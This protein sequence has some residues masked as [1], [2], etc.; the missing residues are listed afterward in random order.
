MSAVP[1]RPRLGHERVVVL[2]TLAGGAPAL[3]LL[4][5]LNWRGQGAASRDWLL[6][7]FAAVWWFVL[8]AAVRRRVV[9]PL[10]TLGNLLACLRDGDTSLRARGAGTG[11]ALAEVMLEA[12]LL[13]GSLQE[14]RLDAREAS[15][16]L[17]RVMAEIDV[18]VC[19]FDADRRTR[20]VNHAGERLLGEPVDRLLNRTADALGLGPCLDAPPG[21]LTPLSLDGRPGRWEV[22]RSVFRLG[23]VPHTLLVLTDV[24]RSLRDEERQAWQRLIRVLGHE[25]NNSLAPIRSIAASLARLVERQWGQADAREDM[26]RGLGVVA[27]RA[28]ALG[29]FTAASS[30][31]A[32]LPEP[33]RRT[34]DL[35]TLIQ[36]VAALDHRV[37]VCVDAGL[38]AMVFVDP[39]QFEQVLINLVKNGAE[40]MAG[41]PGAV[42]I[43]WRQKG[44]AVEITIEDDGVG[45][46]PTTNLFVPFFTTKPGGSG[47]GLVLARQI[48]EAHGG[49]LSLANRDG[50]NGCAATLMLPLD[51][52][53]TGDRRS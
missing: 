27:S 28:E 20:I 10:R 7:A 21:P 41:H 19:A 25:L 17:R 32:H 11:D 30:T 4:V 22:R 44:P 3:V 45:L 47:I 1:P 29:R 49:T 53:P 36:R 39:D 48:V 31:L 14:Q 9:F 35:A 38:P 43:R 46:A 37:P 50:A 26:T 8:A 18:V 2:L 24:S 51:P 42:T 16:L 6:A 15:A 23:G 12:N 34:S 5:F 33:R 13:V 40:A 52:A